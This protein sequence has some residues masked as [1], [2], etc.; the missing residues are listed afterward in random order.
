MRVEDLMQRE[1]AVVAE[2]ASLEDAGRLLQDA[3]SDVLPVAR[4]GRL[5][6]TVGW[7][8]LALG[9]CAAGLDPRRTRVAQ[10]MTPRLGD[11]PPD[12]DPGA[13]LARMR[14]QAAE[15]V[16]VGTGPQG[17]VG[18]LTRRRLLEALVM[19]DDQ[20]RGPAPEHVKR[21]RGEPL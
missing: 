14:E 4:Q 19:P 18:F 6:G 12:A 2:S 9:G 20:D 3:G 15:A 1:F 10:V 8:E 7:R 21:V 16:A 5:A 13:V 17:V 11:C